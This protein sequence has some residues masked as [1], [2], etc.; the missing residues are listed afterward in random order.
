MTAPTATHIV[1]HVFETP[2]HPEM[3]FGY[4][5]FWLDTVSLTYTR[6]GQDSARVNAFLRGRSTDGRDRGNYV[7]LDWERRTEWPD[8]VSAAIIAHLPAG[9]QLDDLDVYCGAED[10]DECDASD[11]CCAVVCGCCSRSNDCS[12]SDGGDD[13][14]YWCSEHRLSGDRG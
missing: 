11:P 13:A 9:W 7:S 14:R 5:R 8:R 4:D 1:N 2:D 10:C 12:L 3:R 6:H